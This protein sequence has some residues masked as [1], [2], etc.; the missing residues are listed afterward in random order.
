MNVLEKDEALV[1]DSSTEICSEE[2]STVLKANA[3][4]LA[5]HELETTI[6][7]HLSTGI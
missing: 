2:V 3:T 4:S 5:C 1:L 6:V 7:C